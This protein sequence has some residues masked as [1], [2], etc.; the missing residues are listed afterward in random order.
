MWGNLAAFAVS[1]GPMVGASLAGGISAALARRGSRH[2]PSPPD[3]RTSDGALRV[4]LLLVGAAWL[5]IVLADL[6]NMSRAEVERIW[7]PFAPWAL[8]GLSLFAPKTRQIMLALQ[9]V[10]AIVVQSLLH[11]GW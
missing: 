8:V 6:S 3:A 4:V 9:I 2:D 11:T 10:F 1:A 7:L 5:T